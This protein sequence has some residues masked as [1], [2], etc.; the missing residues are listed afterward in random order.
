MSWKSSALV[1]AVAAGV[2][3]A[4]T[5]DPD[6][7]GRPTTIPFPQSSPWDPMIATL[8]K[9]L[10][11]D[12]RLSGA[13]NMSCATCHNPSFG[14]ETPVDLA[15]GAA[16]MPLGR[17]APTTLNLAWTDSFFWDGRAPSL[18]AQ[19]LGP[20]TADVEMNARMED[21]VGRL[22]MVPEY[23]EWFDRLFPGQGITE[24][25]VLQSIATFERTLVSGPAPFDR[26]VAGDATALSAQQQ[27]GFELFIGRAGCAACHMGWNMTDNAFHDI[28]LPTDDIGRAGV[29]GDPADRFAF[30]TP[31]LRNITLRAPF[32]HNGMLADLDAVIRHYAGGGVDRPSR[33]GLM[34][35]F[36]VSDSEIADLVAFM[37]SLTEETPRIATPI[38]P[39]N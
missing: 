32:M 24:A 7:W 27:R 14:W 17:H 31:G 15:V 10:F 2:A 35:P 18:E 16:N 22:A 21:V 29:T 34:Q 37:A 28:G 30:K 8:G 39:A 25:T 23:A 36:Q 20:I 4:G 9:M 33:S 19:A 13:Q 1:L 6:L 38:L 3:V 11:F 26:W 5:P 12:P